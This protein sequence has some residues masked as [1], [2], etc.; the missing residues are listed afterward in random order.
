MRRIKSSF[1]F[2]CL[3]SFTLLL[4]FAGSADGQALI[5]N[6]QD[7]TAPYGLLMQISMAFILT[8]L[9]LYA[10]TLIAKYANEVSGSSVNQ[11]EDTDR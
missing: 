3:I 11:I 5:Q 1:A 4:L 8:L 9:T 7:L 10:I 6:I 2:I